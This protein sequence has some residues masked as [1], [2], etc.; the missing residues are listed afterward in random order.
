LFFDQR[1]F[2][3]FHTELFK[4]VDFDAF[5]TCKCNEIDRIN[6]ENRSFKCSN[7]ANKSNALN[8]EKKTLL[9]CTQTQQED[10]DKSMLREHRADIHETHALSKASWC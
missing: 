3:Y 8:K 6:F 7:E 4:C 1:I 10:L 2:S 9:I 5:A